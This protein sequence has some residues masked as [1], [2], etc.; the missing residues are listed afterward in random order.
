MTYLSRI[1][2]NPLRAASR[3]LLSSP[4]ALHGAV[5]AG[6][7]VPDP[8]E[9]VLWRLDTDDPRRPDLFV[10]TTSRPD[11]THVVEQAGWPGADGEHAAVRDYGPLLGQI[12]AGREFAFR[13]TANPVQN[14]KNPDKPTPSQTERAATTTRSFRIG[15]RTAPA[16]MNWFLDRTA[17]WGF[18]VPAS[19]C[20]PPEPGT[21]PAA[22]PPREV[23]ITSR[24]RRSFTKNGREHPS[25]STPRPSRG[26]S[27][28]P[29][30][31]PAPNGSSAGS[32]PA[33]HTAAACSPLPPCAEGTP[34]G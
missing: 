29:T 2:I 12:A 25:C 26:T 7:A 27:A 10:L 16:Q 15:H 3:N 18:D 33:R 17:R 9:R 13:L 11:W 23:R 19:R 28:S 5:M 22:E 1:R 30:P 14:V 4:R 6:I 31:A 34:D 24:E 8:A 32:G 21:A 20:D